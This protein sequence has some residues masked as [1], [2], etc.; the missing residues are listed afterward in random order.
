MDK[1][2]RAGTNLREV[3]S[4]DAPK[5]TITVGGMVL[6]LKFVMSQPQYEV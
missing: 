4:P 6:L 2:K 5:M 1:L 3:K